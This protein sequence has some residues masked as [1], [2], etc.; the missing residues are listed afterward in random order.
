MT[1]LLKEFNAVQKKIL[2]EGLE[3]R[4]ITINAKIKESFSFAVLTDTHLI[5]VDGENDSVA[6]KEIA[7]KRKIYFRGAEEKLA[8]ALS[9]YDATENLKK[10]VHCGDI[11]D[12]STTDSWLSFVNIMGARLENT[13]IAPGNHEFTDYTD[14]FPKTI[15][16]REAYYINFA[17][18]MKNPPNFYSEIINGVNLI[19]MD[20]ALTYFTE[21]QIE[22][23]KNEIEKGYPI[24]LFYHVPLN[25]DGLSDEDMIVMNET[26]Q[27]M[28]DLICAN[29]DIIKAAITGHRHEEITGHF[30]N[31]SIPQ[32]ILNGSYRGE[33]GKMTIVTVY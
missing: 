16:G 9:F 6:Q 13:I 7:V 17:K 10:I 31:S 30:Y 29:P 3:V 28:Y 23:L 22:K 18:Y 12:A 19:T 21:E 8:R 14:G 1:E 2:D 32:Y 4:G 20:N 25:M 5:S 33:A 26:T 27:K 15:E 24:I 11:V